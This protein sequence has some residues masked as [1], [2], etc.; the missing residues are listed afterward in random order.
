MYA[1]AAA[2][3]CL[4]TAASTHQALAQGACGGPS[5][6]SGDYGMSWQSTPA[7]FT[8]VSPL[9]VTTAIGPNPTSGV[10]TVKITA[11]RALSYAPKIEVLGLDG[12]VV[13]TAEGAADLKEFEAS[14]DLR[15]AR[16]NVFF[17]RTNCEQCRPQ[18]VV[19]N[20]GTQF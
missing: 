1:A 17:V 13:A 5:G 8:V 20:A 19:V 16:G 9:K 2:V 18:K 10:F 6:H 7:T 4:L 15:N 12:R 14:F 3:F 11:N